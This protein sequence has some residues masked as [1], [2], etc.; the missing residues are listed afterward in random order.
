[1]KTAAIIVAAGAG[2]RA[3]GVM[4][5]QFAPVAGLPMVAHSVRAFAAHPAVDEVLVVVASGQEALARAIV[6]PAVRLVVGGAARRNS[7]ANGLA[8]TDAARVLIHDAARPFVPAAV[9][10]RVMQALD[11]AAGST[12]VLAVADTLARGDGTLDD[13]VSR[14]GLWRIQTPQGFD[15][16]V[17]RRAH[18]TWDAAAEATDDAQ[19]VRALGV[20]VTLVQ[21][22]PMLDKVT[23]PEDFAAAGARAGWGVA[24]RD[25]VRRASAGGGRGVVA[26]RRA[27]PA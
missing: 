22:D 25:R 8:A 10:E 23:H 16:A 9:I 13:L 12:P 14:A 26:G 1:M 11:G 21:G 20:D 3:G 18:A 15:A 17:L 27:D 6:G 7:V 19:M 4:P 2:T 5:K 24:H